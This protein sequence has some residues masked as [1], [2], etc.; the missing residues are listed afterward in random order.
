MPALAATRYHAVTE[1]KH[2]EWCDELKLDKA[3]SDA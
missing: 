2:F 1:W 3:A